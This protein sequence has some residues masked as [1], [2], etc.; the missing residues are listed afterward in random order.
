MKNQ[1]LMISNTNCEEILAKDEKLKMRDKWVCDRLRCAFGIGLSG[2]GI[3]AGDPL[4]EQCPEFTTIEDIV[5]SV[6]DD[7]LPQAIKAV[8][9]IIDS[10]IEIIKAKY[11]NEQAI[12]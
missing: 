2:L 4:I 1:R 6:S 9:M 3:C 10:D 12:K 7:D 8:C 5:G 11:L